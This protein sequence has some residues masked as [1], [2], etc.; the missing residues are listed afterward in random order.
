[1]G[2]AFIFGVGAML[3]PA[4]AWLFINQE[5]RLALPFLGLTYKPWRLFMVVC[6]VPG[7][8]CGLSLFKI[9][10]SPKFLL[11]MGQE[12]KC[13]EILQEIYSFNTGKPKE[14]F[15]VSLMLLY[16]LDLVIK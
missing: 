13:V 9:P 6:G 12:E 14:E 8:L 5:W 2:S 1:M 10:E 7:L 16:I 4:I 3:M 15:P 11:S